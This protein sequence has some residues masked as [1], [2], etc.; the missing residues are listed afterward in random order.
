MNFSLDLPTGPMAEAIVSTV[1]S[2][3][4][5]AVFN[6]SV[7]SF[8]F[9]EILA[10]HEGC[11]EDDTYDRDLLFAATV[12]H[13]LGTGNLAKGEA[14]FEVEGADL[15][16]DLLRRHPGLPRSDAPGGGGGADPGAERQVPRGGSRCR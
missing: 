5:A 6:H 12:L 7:R 2:S 16:A 10:A 15:A 8:L 14:R 13:D 3:E 11:L 1:R 4:T 9:A